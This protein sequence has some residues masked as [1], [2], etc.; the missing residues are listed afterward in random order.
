M[1]K[2]LFKHF[3]NCHFREGGRGCTTADKQVRAPSC[4]TV[5]GTKMLNCLL[6]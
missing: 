3:S 2:F 4:L 5:K 1:C 6:C